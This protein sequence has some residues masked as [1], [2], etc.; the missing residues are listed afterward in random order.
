MKALL[1]FL[2]A[3]A[4]SAPAN[5]QDFSTKDELS[6]VAITAA[7]VLV[8][9]STASFLSSLSIKE[10]RLSEIEKQ[11]LVDQALEMKA[12][13]DGSIEDS[14]FQSTYPELFRYQEFL[15]NKAPKYRRMSR[16]E[17]ADEILERFLKVDQKS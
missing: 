1:A 12:N 7:V 13:E 3:F 10:N 17:L 2:F 15:R 6:S 8:P 11:E 9:I 4:Y 14:I 16:D 5:A